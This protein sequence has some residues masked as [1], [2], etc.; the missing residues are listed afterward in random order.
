MFCCF[1]E[2][3]FAKFVLS[4]LGTEQIRFSDDKYKFVI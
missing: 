2:V 1:F 3:R 4:F